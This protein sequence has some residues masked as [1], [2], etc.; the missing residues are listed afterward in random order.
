MSDAAD[1][2]FC[3]DNPDGAWSGA[4]EDIDF[5]DENSDVTPV[6]DSADVTMR[7]DVSGDAVD[8]IFGVDKV[9]EIAMGDAYHASLCGDDDVI[10]WG[11]TGDVTLCNIDPDVSEMLCV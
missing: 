4:E 8:V 1:A 7:D 6:S 5:C 10:G 11:D 2:T 3:G 9:D